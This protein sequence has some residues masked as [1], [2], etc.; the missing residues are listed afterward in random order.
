MVLFRYAG[1]HNNNVFWYACVQ[2]ALA[3]AKEEAAKTREALAVAAV[4]T[5]EAESAL[6][7]ERM[8]VII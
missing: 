2:E 6:R 4:K 3:M 8:E 5:S 7:I 1:D